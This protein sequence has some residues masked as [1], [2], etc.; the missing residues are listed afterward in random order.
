MDPQ[1]FPSLGG[2]AALAA[3]VEG[4]G[5]AQAAKRLSIGQSALTKRLQALQASYPVRLF[6]HIN[7]QLRLTEAGERVYAL[8]TR[9]LELQQATWQELQALSQD[10]P[11]LRISATH[12]ISEYLLPELLVAYQAHHPDCQV[13]SHV[14]YWLQ[15]LQDLATGTSAD[16]A[17]LEQPLDHPEILMQKWRDDE[18]WLVCRPDHPFA[19]HARIAPSQISALTLIF[20]ETDSSIRETVENSLHSFGVSGL[21]VALEIGPSEA[22][23]SAIRCSDHMGFLPRFA[24][25]ARVAAG[26]LQRI[27]MEGIEIKRALWLARN[28]KR[29][30]H[31]PSEEFIG[32]LRDW[33]ESADNLT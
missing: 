6:S 18:L 19:E 12:D 5:V 27:E 1:R 22:I 17:L 7:G 2:L 33:Q 15:I 11:L 29:L 20:R 31:A 21:N 8:A 16:V 28:R 10:K 24:V 25:Q 13:K 14:A 32:L 30:G 9:V 3:L 26:E 4:G 23:I